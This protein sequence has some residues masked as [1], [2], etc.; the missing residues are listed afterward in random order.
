[1]IAE[2]VRLMREHEIGR[3][4]FGR[5]TG[6]TIFDHDLVTAIVRGLTLPDK[7]VPRKSGRSRN[8]TRPRSSMRWR[9]WDCGD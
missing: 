2:R 9:R 7:S 3:L 1:L 4:F 6:E 5:D 8:A